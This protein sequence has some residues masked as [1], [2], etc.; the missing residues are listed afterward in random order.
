MRG[1]SDGTCAGGGADGVNDANGSL[2]ADGVSK[3]KPAKPPSGGAASGAFSSS[4]VKPKSLACAVPRVDA[5]AGLS[6]TNDGESNEK[7]ADAGAAAAGSAAS[8]LA[9]AG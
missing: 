5:G 9:M 6:T 1:P 7:A 4:K 3:E 2:D 8:I